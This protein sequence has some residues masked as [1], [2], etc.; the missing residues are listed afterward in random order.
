MW[1]KLPEH[2]LNT[3]CVFKNADSESAIQD[4]KT[5][6]PN[7]ITDELN[8]VLFST[9]G[10]HGSYLTIENVEKDGGELTFLVIH[11]RTVTVRYGNCRPISKDDFEFLKKLR[12]SS[13]SVISKIGI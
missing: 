8:F 4:L 3:N 10:V 6:F 13:L 2:K 11:P 7:G 9:S 12:D 5:L 1:K